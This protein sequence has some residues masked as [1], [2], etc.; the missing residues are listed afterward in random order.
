M[1]EAPA[2]PHTK[3]PDF[4]RGSDVS[5]L[6]S[7]ISPVAHGTPIG[8]AR[9]YKKTGATARGRYATVSI[10]AQQKTD[11]EQPPAANAPDDSKKKGGEDDEDDKVERD[12]EEVKK[13][14]EK[15][16]KEEKEEEEKKEGEEE[17]EEDAEEEEAELFAVKKQALQSPPTVS[18]VSIREWRVFRRLA[19][20]TARRQCINFVKMYEC[21]V[22]RCAEDDRRYVD[23]VLEYADTRLTDALRARQIDFAGFREIA[24]QLVWALTTAEQTME[25]VHNDLHTGNILLQRPS[26]RTLV[27]HRD[28]DGHTWWTSAWVVKIIDFGLSRIKLEDGTVISNPAVSLQS[29]YAPYNDYG[30]L[31]KELDRITAGISDW[32][33]V[34]ASDKEKVRSFKRALRKAADQLS[35]SIAHL[36]E[37]DLFQPLRVMP[38]RPA[39][40]EEQEAPVIVELSLEGEDPEED[41]EEQKGR[42]SDTFVSSLSSRVAAL[43][44]EEDQDGEEQ[45]EEKEKEEELKKEEEKE[46]EEEQVK[47]KPQRRAAPK[48]KST[49]RRTTR[50]TRAKKQA[51]KPA[52][53]DEEDEEE[54]EDELP[55]SPPTPLKSTKAR[56]S[57]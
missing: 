23:F 20:L 38:E 40:A 41:E 52:S 17:Q 11:K 15:E 53:S 4:P 7:I 8:L 21:F 19:Q 30:K 39:S 29:L 46:E 45:E 2:T 25:F 35:L 55:P 1:A 33:D 37:H 42:R 32:A 36:L 57:K 48:R 16:E 27:A 14:E 3:H 18:D 22:E 43:D 28:S 9:R 54:E 31:H 47:K 12:E 34:P 56:K 13:E 44:I 5:P 10:V 24:F 51:A 50:Q 26:Q 6:L 49:G